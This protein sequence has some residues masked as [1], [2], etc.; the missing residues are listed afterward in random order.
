MFQ[1]LVFEFVTGQRLPGRPFPS[2][3]YFTSRTASAIDL[4]IVI[5]ARVPFSFYLPSRNFSGAPVYPS[6]VI[7]HMHPSTQS[8]F[9]DLRIV[10]LLLIRARPTVS[11][12]R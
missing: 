9:C 10:L 5:R 3:L 8:E 6:S 7:T 12:I 2:H 1:V 11:L 4:S